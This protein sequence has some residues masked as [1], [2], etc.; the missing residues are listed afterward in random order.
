MENNNQSSYSFWSWVIAIIVALILLITHFTGNGARNTCCGAVAETAPVV[1]APIVTEAFN[2]SATEYDFTSTGDAS[3]VTWAGD[4]IDTLKALLAGGITAAGD[5]RAVVLTGVVD[6]DE[7]K[8]QKGTDA[9]VFF[10]PDVTIDNQI[11]VE[12]IEPVVAEPVAAIPPPAAKLYFD[13]GVHR[14]PAGSDVTLEPIIAWLNDNVDA[15]AV[16]SGFHDPTGSVTRNIQLAKNRA[17]SAYDALVNAGIDPARI[18]MRKPASTTG[19]GDLAEA[20]R[21]EVSVE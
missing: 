8:Q 20:R 6:A 5:D 1:E 4:S 19:D 14:L 13:T 7:V 11:T 17:Q 12:M 15:T 18:E 3:L 21:V 2:F 10:G 16:V 9:Q